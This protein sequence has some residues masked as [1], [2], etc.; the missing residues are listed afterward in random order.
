VLLMLAVSSS[1]SPGWTADGTVIR[2]TLRVAER[3]ATATNEMGWVAAT[4]TWLTLGGPSGLTNAWAAPVL[5]ASTEVPPSATRAI[6]K[7]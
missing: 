5:I 7:R 2:G 6:A 3:V 4:E 1:R